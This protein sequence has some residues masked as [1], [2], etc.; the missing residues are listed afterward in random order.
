MA[1]LFLY[2]PR[3]KEVQPGNPDDPDVQKAIEFMEEGTDG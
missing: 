3:G 1:N 2:F